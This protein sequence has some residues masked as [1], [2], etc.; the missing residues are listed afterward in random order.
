MTSF[1]AIGRLLNGT[2]AW[3]AVFV[4]RAR[5][6][7][8][9]L[10]VALSLTSLSNAR[11]ALSLPGS[12]SVFP[13][14]LL[15]LAAVLLW[16]AERIFARE[17][18]VRSASPLLGW[19]LL[20]FSA[21]LVPGIVRGH[22]RFGLSLV[23]Q[24]I[25]LVLYAAIG[26]AVLQLRPRDLYWGL[27]GVLYAGAAWQLALGVYGLLTGVHQSGAYLLS[28]G[29]AR[30]LSLG[31]G[32]YLAS[33]FL[34]AL[35]NIEFDRGR[36]RWLH[37]GAAGVALVAEA[38]TFGRSTFVAL[39]L[40]LPVLFLTLR[41]T[42]SFVLRRWPVLAA[43]AVVAIV[44]GA[45]TPS[46]GSTLVDRVTANPLNDTTVRWRIGSLEAALSGFRSGEWRQARLP[47]GVNHLNDSTFEHGI[48]DWHI[49][50]G[51]MRTL[52]TNFPT[53]DD[54]A[55]RFETQ[56]T[57]F[58]EGPY[59]KP[60]LTDLGQTWK[61][62]VWLRGAQGGELVNVGIW[63]YGTDGTHTGYANLPVVLTDQLV[64]HTIQVTVRD[65][66]TTYVRAIVR[67]RSDPQKATV[68]AD[69]A[70][71]TSVPGPAMVGSPENS[72]QNPGFE[73]GTTG[74]AMQGGTLESTPAPT[75]MFGQLSARMKT[76]GAVVDEGIYSSPVPAHP[77][78][79]WTFS[80]W[81]KG[82]LGH[83]VVAVEIW[84]Y[85]ANGESTHFTMAPFEL[86]STLQRYYVRTRIVK[87]DTTMIRGLVRTWDFP[88]AVDVTV[89]QASL[90]RAGAEA[91]AKPAAGNAYPGFLEPVLGVGFGRTFNYTWNG[92]AYHLEGDPH[93]SYIWILAGSG[94]FALASLLVLMAV[95]LRDAIKRAR[96][97]ISFD[98]A[99]VLWAI[100]TWFIFLLN[101]LTGPILSEPTF[102]LTVW[103]VILL[104]AIVSKSRPP[105]E[106][107]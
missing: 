56:G 19:P 105:R 77:G 7:I 73:A 70:S 3:P 18:A 17:P 43:F 9:L 75:P 42:R 44:V 45:M 63:E 95:F 66:S 41:E 98:R 106:F 40:L 92:Y 31:A 81:L 49:Q 50:G 38:L 37:L 27:V 6:A 103:I 102:L 74:W 88:S 48:L 79:D 12:V 78:E 65:P 86:S 85:S 100:V 68:Y 5:L 71:L 29:G 11:A 80:V 93:N 94:I 14:D 46:I 30:V 35:L 52:Q 1:V 83:E 84:E 101:A 55:L 107:H 54:R 26:L 13:S 76:A 67:T 21:S 104:P 20:L 57:S 90:R 91:L 36:R 39:A 8:V 69:Q 97:A 25:R 34:I 62:T 16:V 2:S 96:A 32:M 51:K 53:F 10:A 89:D 24:P 28:T 99:L 61:F 82:A 64:Q 23:G 33:A 15:V 58:D 87:S 60:V 59:S 72:L 22:E 47:D 4:Y